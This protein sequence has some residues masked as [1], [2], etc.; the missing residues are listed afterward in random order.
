MVRKDRVVNF[1]DRRHT[2]VPSVMAS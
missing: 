2:A 1:H